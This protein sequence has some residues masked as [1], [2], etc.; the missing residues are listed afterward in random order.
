MSIDST[1][2]E[3]LSRLDGDAQLLREL[4]EIFLA[5]SPS[6]LQQVSDAVT[7]RDPDALQRAAHKL[8]GTVSIFGS[9]PVMRTAV[10][11]ET[12]GGDRTHAGEVLTQL[13]DQMKEL[14]AA[15]GEMMQET[16]PSA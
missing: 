8:S 4:I 15:L 12:M 6:L 3:L 14:E 2:R 9:Q 16:C 10:T 1:D 11:L 7:S 5:D 13:K